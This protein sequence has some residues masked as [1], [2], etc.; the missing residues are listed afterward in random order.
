MTKQLFDRI[1]ELEAQ[2]ANAA[3]ER[4]VLG[5]RAYGAHQ[6][7][8]SMHNPRSPEQP[9]ACDCGWSYLRKSLANAT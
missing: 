2:L 1:D 9:A 4:L 5:L 3:I 8:C 6:V 7:G